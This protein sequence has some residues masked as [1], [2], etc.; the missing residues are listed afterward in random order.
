VTILGYDEDRPL[1]QLQI[2]EHP[3]PIGDG[4]GR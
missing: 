2:G 1:D 4:S 3:D